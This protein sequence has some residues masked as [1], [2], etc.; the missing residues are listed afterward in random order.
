MENSDALITAHLLIRFF[1]L[2]DRA[3]KLIAAPRDPIRK[4]I[5]AIIYSY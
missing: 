1:A 4:L 3:S 5:N 2:N